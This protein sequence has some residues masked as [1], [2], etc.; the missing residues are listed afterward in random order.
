MSQQFFNNN[1]S[2]L[3]ID[4]VR[5]THKRYSDKAPQTFSGRSPLYL[6]PLI[7]AKIRGEASE[8]STINRVCLMFRLLSLKLFVSKVLSSAWLCRFAPSG[9]SPADLLKTE[10]IIN[11]S[12]I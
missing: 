4:A 7:G 9:Q 11:D 10:R 1:F 5:D 2:A 8:R 12:P 6:K 3:P